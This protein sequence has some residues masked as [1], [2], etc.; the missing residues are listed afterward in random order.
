ME[1]EIFDPIGINNML[2]K[3]RYKKIHLKELLEFFQAKYFYNWV[4]ADCSP[5][6]TEVVTEQEASIYCLLMYGNYFTP[7]LTYPELAAWK[8]L[9]HY[10][11]FLYMKDCQSNFAY[12]R[13]LV[14]RLDYISKYDK[15]S[16]I[17]WITY[18]SIFQFNT[19]ML[20]D[21]TLNFYSRIPNQKIIYYKIITNKLITALSIIHNNKLMK[22]QLNG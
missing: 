3:Y 4:Y 9:C 13:P 19:K 12:D 14:D 11:E 21:N 10:V 18:D 8:Q 1:T 2:T 7:L 6:L 20:N 15:V 5:T 16:D 22:E 17:D